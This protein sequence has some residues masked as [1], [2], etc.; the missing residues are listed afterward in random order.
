L[1]S[2]KSGKKIKM[3]YI[4]QEEK[5][6][7]S[8]NKFIDFD[9]SKNI[10]YDNLYICDQKIVVKIPICKKLRKK[11]NRIADTNRD[12]KIERFNL[13]KYTYLISY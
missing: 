5:D 11:Q 1:R 8:V 2:R 3:M 6:A 13:T 7:S 9:K 4:P 10:F 12:V